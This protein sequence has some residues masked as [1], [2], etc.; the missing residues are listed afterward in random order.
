[1]KRERVII[2]NSEYKNRVEK[3]QQMMQEAGWSGMVLSSESNMH[4]Y[5]G[6]RTHL[7]W[8][9]FTRPM[10]L[11]LPAKG[12]PIVYTQGFVS[13]E[14]AFRAPHMEHRGFMS[15]LGPTAKELYDLMAEVGMASGIVGF[16]IGH[17]QRINYQVD[18]FLELAKML[19]KVEIVDASQIIWKQRLIKSPLEIECHRRACQ[20]TNYVFDH[21]FEQI[22]EGMDE[23]E[24]TNLVRR[25]MLEGGADKDGFVIIC[26]GPE[27]CTRTSSVSQN[28]RLKK[29]DML[30]LDLGCEY[31]GYYSDFCRAGIVGPVD[32]ERKHQ[33]DDVYQATM[34]AASK[35]IPG[36]PV[37]ELARACGAGLENRG[38]EVVYD[39]GRLG[40]G[41]GLVSTEPPSVTVFEEGELQAGQII[42]I[43]PTFIT[44]KG[45]FCL[46]ENIVVTENGC[47][48]MSGS[49]RELH[50]I[51]TL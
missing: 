42:T 34:E 28:S 13:P 33:Q 25:L 45:V 9:T 4:Y 3:A 32:D 7:P 46:E 49:S 23:Y 29:G 5:S 35:I 12:K 41:M 37:K 51:P 8:G 19:D 39:F 11:F 26:A 24:I 10:F 27:E 43:E 1:M 6:Y 20:A 47:E 17:E 22:N 48:I 16:E 21:V 31:E 18:C 15:M 2:P 38:Y 40:H 44:D 36:L 30:W 50:S 14:A